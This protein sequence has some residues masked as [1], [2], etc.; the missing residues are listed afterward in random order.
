MHPFETVFIKT[1]RDIVDHSYLKSLE[2]TQALSAGEAASAYHAAP[3]DGV[4][5]NIQSAWKGH[6]NFATWLVTRLK[7]GVVVDLGIESGYSA[8]CFAR[9]SI[10]QVFGIDSFE[11]DIHFGR[12]D[13]FAEVRN[14][15]S[16]LGL[17]NVTLVRGRSEE[18]AQI[19]DKEVGILHIDGC[20]TYADAKRNYESWSNFVVPDGIVLLHGTC[21]AN[22]GVRRLFNEIKL[23]KTNFAIACGLGVISKNESLISEIAA[24]FSSLIEPGTT[25]LM[26]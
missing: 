18:V 14:S 4:L 1:S 26:P 15:I 13:T 12:R 10:G 22:Y 24:I 11:G 21:V 19:W 8:F 16:Q 9:S 25:A 7:P 5:G 20:H 23:P 17:S 2:A 3:L 6:G